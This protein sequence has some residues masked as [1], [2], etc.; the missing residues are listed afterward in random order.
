MPGSPLDPR[1]RG[2]NQLIKESA[3]LVESADDITE[4]LAH[5]QLIHLGEPGHREDDRRAAPPIDESIVKDF[6]SVITELLSPTPCDIDDLIRES[7]APPAA[8]R[9]VLTELALAEKLDRLPGG[10]VA[11]KV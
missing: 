4:I 1:C 3:H 6:R 8:V 2:C 7:G 5:S 9:A 11:L 10:K